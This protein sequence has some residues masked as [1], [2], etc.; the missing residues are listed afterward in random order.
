MKRTSERRILSLVLALLLLIPAFSQADIP[1]PVALMAGTA[2]ESLHIR[3]SEPEIKKLAQFDENRT[4]QLNRLIR[5]IGIDISLDGDLSSTGILVDGKE[6]VSFLQKDLDDRTERIYSFE[7]KTVREGKNDD[8]ETDGDDFTVFLEQILLKAGRYMDEFY[9]LF[10]AAPE[11]FADRSRKEGTELRFSGFGKAVQ[12]VTIS[13]PANYVQ[14]NF[15]EA[16]AGLARTESFKAYINGLTFSGN[17][18]IGLLYDE[19]GKIVRIN[20]DGKVGKTPETLRKVTLVWKVLREENHLK[21]SISLKTPAVTGA[22]KDNISLERDL[23][24]TDGSAGTYTWDVQIDHRAGKEDV[25]QTRFTAELN[26]TESVISGSMEY[27]Y[28]R[29]GKNPKLRI[30]PEIRKEKDGEYKGTLEIAD[31]SGK[32]EK[33]RFLAQVQLQKGADVRWPETE[34]RKAETDQ[35]GEPAEQQDPEETIA[36]MLIQ[37]LFELPEEDLAYFSNEIPADLWLELIH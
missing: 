35:S 34:L 21:D 17:Q 33:N 23:D 25:K 3:V 9:P 10:A 24:S 7:P 26:D 2:P 22:D 19:N 14:E 13:F 1:L 18:K 6:I 27:S 31:Y 32:I 15:P 4:E 20:Y 5:H 28:K 30:F 29:N 36:G 16:L 11:A 37:K 8:T 12:R